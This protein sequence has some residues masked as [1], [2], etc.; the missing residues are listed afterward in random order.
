MQSPSMAARF[1]G[2]QPMNITQIEGEYSRLTPGAVMA[3]KQE[4]NIEKDM[5]SLTIEDKV[6][7][8]ADWSV[9]DL[10]MLT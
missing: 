3:L 8:S 2:N 4:A 7:T 6:R 1:L 5:P 10:Q 9:L